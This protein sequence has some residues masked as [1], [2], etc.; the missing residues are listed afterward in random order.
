MVLTLILSYAHEAYIWDYKNEF[1]VQVYPL[2][3]EDW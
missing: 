1:L 2:D 3:W